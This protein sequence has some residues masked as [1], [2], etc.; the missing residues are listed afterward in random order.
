[1][2]LTNEMKK[3]IELLRLQRI[4]YKKIAQQLNLPLA[5]VKSYCRRHEL[6]ATDV[7]IK[8]PRMFVQC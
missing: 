1:M 4:G 8:A 2:R 7:S 5:T 6:K 3:D